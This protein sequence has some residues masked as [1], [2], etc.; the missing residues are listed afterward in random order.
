MNKR[1]TKKSLKGAA[2]MKLLGAFFPEELCEGRIESGLTGRGELVQGGRGEE[3]SG[4]WG[5]SPQKALMLT[6]SG[7][8]LA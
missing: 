7:L 2:D 3:E 8:D 4:G 1:Q 5:C 6:V